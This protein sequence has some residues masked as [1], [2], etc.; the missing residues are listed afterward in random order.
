MI[1][2]TENNMNAILEDLYY[3][4]SYPCERINPATPK[5][6]ELTHLLDAEMAALREKLSPEELARLNR[7][8]DHQA[9]LS[10]IEHFFAFKEGLRFGILLLGEL[11]RDN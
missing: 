6:R 3:G 8:E 5:Y 2:R 9:E 1:G 7:A 10:N 11:L 4:K